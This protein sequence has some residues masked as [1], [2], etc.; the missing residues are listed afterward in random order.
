MLQVAK[1]DIECEEGP[2][3]SQMGIVVNSWSTDIKPHKGR[4]DGFEFFLLPAKRI[5]QPEGMRHAAKVGKMR[6]VLRLVSFQKMWR[7]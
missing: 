1:E 7:K 5:I 2:D 3:I 4:I 6:K